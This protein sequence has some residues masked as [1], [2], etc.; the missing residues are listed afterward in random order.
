MELILDLNKQYTFADYLQWF[1]DKRREL[2]EGFVKKMP[3]PTRYHQ[4][5]SGI[6]FLKFGNYLTD[7]KCEVYSAPFDVRLPQNGETDDDKI[8]T[9]VQPDIVVVCSPEKLDEKG[10]IGAPDLIIEITSKSTGRKDL[11]DKYLI[12]EK[13]GVKEYWIAFPETKSINIFLLNDSGK[14]ELEKIYVEGDIISPVLFPDLNI[15]VEE[16]FKE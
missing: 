8:H 10:C 5:V 13:S 9:V 12:Y 7:K 1:D 4:K 16:V 14:Y 3:A 6:L 2:F 15:D 11:R